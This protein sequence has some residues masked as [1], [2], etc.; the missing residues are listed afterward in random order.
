MKSPMEGN[1]HVHYFCVIFIDLLGQREKL[2]NISK[3]PTNKAEETQ[4]VGLI[5]QSFGKVIRIRG[6]FDKYFETAVSYEPDTSSIRPE[7]PDEFCASQQAKLHF[8]TFS[9]SLTI[10][11]PLKSDA[12]ENCA[13]IN[14]IYCALVATS[15]IGL[16]A[17]LDQAPFRAGIDVGLAAEIADQEIYGPALERAFLLESQ[18][19]EYPR[20]LVGNGFFN[21]LLYVEQQVPKRRMGQYAKNMAALCRKMI[22]VDSDGRMMLDFLNVIESLPDTFT[23][24]E[25]KQASDYVSSQYR[26]YVE[27]ENDKLASRYYRL[28]CYF[29][30]R[31][32]NW[33]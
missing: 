4:F 32:S 33:E 5:K 22:M 9:D 13:A 6:L 12:D 21:Y 19:A 7:F 10:S 15:G 25:I 3:I 26:H 20:F 14:G 30:S 31:E 23:K 1:L 27:K 28:M 8:K 17:L 29:K 11:I 24:A 18:M 16:A 2:R